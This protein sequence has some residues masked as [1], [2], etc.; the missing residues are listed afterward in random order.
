MILVWGS[1]PPARAVGDR[2]RASA[3]PVIQVGA[4]D[5]FSVR[6]AS[7]GSHG[8]LVVHGRSVPLNT[9]SAAYLRPPPPGGVAPGEGRPAVLDWA[10]TTP[11][12]VITRPAAAASNN[13]KPYQTGLLRG[14][15]ATVPPTLV[16]TDPAEALAFCR[17][18]G[19][20]VFKSI[21]G[22]RSV[23]RTATTGSLRELLAQ[24]DLTACPTQFQAYVPGPDW[25]VHVIGSLV[26]GC[27][28][29]SPADDY[30]YAERSGH[31]V[32]ISQVAVPAG[33]RELCLRI[34][35]GLSLPLAGIDF[36]RDEAGKW[37]CFE[38]NPSPVFTYYEAHTGQPLTQA[39][40]DLLVSARPP[41]ERVSEP[42][43]PPRTP[44][45]PPASVAAPVRGASPRPRRCPVRA[46]RALRRT[47][48]PPPAAGG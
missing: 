3:E 34:S 29:V 7:D 27:M 10:E 20:V 24:R 12:L 8:T 26:L 48:T 6:P 5:P 25:R 19:R 40:C 15:G 21:S 42:G 43:R 16:T 18:H 44:S 37:L 13:S 14:L 35:A 4:A 28:V 30:R 39:V 36:R 46:G 22:V 1:D 47:V 23:T 41:A 17:R 11:A 33:L 38:A 9:I 45:P 31:P 32:S 2:L